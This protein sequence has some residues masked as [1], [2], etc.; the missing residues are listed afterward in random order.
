MR[1]I[2]V[3]LQVACAL[4]AVY[5]THSWASPLRAAATRRSNLFQTDLSFTPLTCRVTRPRPF[6]ASASAVHGK[7]ALSCNSN[8]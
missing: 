3:I 6:G 5:S 1:F 4:A 8:Y 2:P 7:S